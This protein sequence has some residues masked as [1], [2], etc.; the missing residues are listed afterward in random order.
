VKGNNLVI[1]KETTLLF[2]SKQPCYFKV[3][4][5]VIWKETT[6]LFERNQPCYL[7]GKTLVETTLLI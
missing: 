7:E 2:Q 3:N 6:L 4:N 1:S 5:L